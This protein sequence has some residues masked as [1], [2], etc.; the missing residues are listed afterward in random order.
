LEHL[1]GAAPSAT[2]S[3]TAR[4]RL[5]MECDRQGH[6]LWMS[7]RARTR[8]GPMDNLFA[9]LPAL[10]AVQITQLLSSREPGVR[11]RL[12][13]SL[14][15]AGR[16][17]KVPVHLVRLLALENRVVLA[18][19]I[20]ARASD[21]LPS[22]DEI[23]RALLGLQSKAVSNYFRLVRAEEWLET[24]ASRPRRSVGAVVAEA[25]ETERARLAHELH[26]GANQMVGIK[27]NL[28]TIESIMPD[29][30]EAA[31]KGLERISSLVDEALSEI[32]SV[33]QRLHPPE[34]QRL[35]LGEAIERAWNNMGIPEKFHATLEIHHLELDIP[36]AVR[37]AIYRAAQEGLVNA[38]R[39]SAATEVKL[40]LSQ[41]NDSLHLSV[42]DNGDGFAVHEVLS[43]GPQS[44]L[45]GIG[46]LAMRRQILELNGRFEVKSGP[47]GTKMKVSVPISEN[48]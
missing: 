3:A 17:A 5:L 23:S 1:P 32:R 9:V 27:Q 26:A 34:W 29:A 11:P 47:G 33:S 8:L 6:I 4:E 31:K 14:Q 40:T 12:K 2:A 38:Y 44:G 21:T 36:D 30:P 18:A 46:L 20:R 15:F 41:E 48:R 7:Q 25:L 16:P 45:R 19:E 28:E 13:S 22:Q 35:S 10:Q 43:S 24:R 39:H 42:E 37:F